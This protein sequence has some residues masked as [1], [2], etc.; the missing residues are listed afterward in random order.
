MGIEQAVYNFEDIVP[1]PRELTF[2]EKNLPT[3]LGL[4]RKVGY[5]QPMPEM[6]VEQKVYSSDIMIKMPEIP[7]GA[8][9]DGVINR[10]FVYVFDKVEEIVNAIKVEE[11]QTLTL[12]L[13]L[14]KQSFE[15]FY[16]DIPC[17]GD[18]NM[19][20]SVMFALIAVQN[21]AAQRLEING[22]KVL[23]VGTRDSS[24]TL[25]LQRQLRNE[26]GA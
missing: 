6:S 1:K 9:R 24:I 20:G 25:N 4:A 8:G 26:H 15:D 19:F 12:Q 22:F 18:D 17:R 13:L 16:S 11:T 14:G 21:Y 2:A 3:F 23:G 5:F 10:P 7:Y